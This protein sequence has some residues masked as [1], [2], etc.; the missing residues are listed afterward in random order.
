MKTA[1]R[2]V[3]N[4]VS[5]H[6]IFRRLMK[7]SIWLELKV[8]MLSENSITFSWN[9]LFELIFIFPEISANTHPIEVENTCKSFF[10]QLC[11][12]RFTVYSKLPIPDNVFFYFQIWFELQEISFEASIM[13]ETTTFRGLIKKCSIDIAII[14]WLS[15]IQLTAILALLP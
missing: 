4:I 9:K 3:S 15:A 2:T 12:A 8:A 13:R 1:S 7:N 6:A 5:C 14:A 10:N 11:A